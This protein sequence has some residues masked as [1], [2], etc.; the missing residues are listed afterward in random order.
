MVLAIV[1]QAEHRS[2][3]ARLCQSEIAFCGCFEAASFRPGGPTHSQISRVSGLQSRS[4]RGRWLTSDATTFGFSLKR[5]G[6]SR[7]V[8]TRNESPHHRTACAIPQKVGAIRLTPTGRG[9]AG[10]P[11]LRICATSKCGCG[12]VNHAGGAGRRRSGSE[13]TQGACFRPLLK[14]Q[15]MSQSTTVFGRLNN[16]GGSGQAGTLYRAKRNS[17]LVEDSRLS[18]VRPAPAA[19]CRSRW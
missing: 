15:G 6:A 1:G 13:N 8:S 7:P 10:L 12:F 17:S 4:L 9:C 19:P 11:A 18:V 5:Y 14:M 3:V 2:P 16:E